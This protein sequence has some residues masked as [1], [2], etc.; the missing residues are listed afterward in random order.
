M[1]T[2]A[3]CKKE[4]ALELG[5]VLGLRLALAGLGLRLVLGLIRKLS[6]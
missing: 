5:L 3:K 2:P 6:A 1:C 4:L